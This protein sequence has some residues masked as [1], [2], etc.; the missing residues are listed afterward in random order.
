MEGHQQG[1]AAL[2]PPEAQQRVF[3]IDV[4]EPQQPHGRVAGSRGHEDGDDGPIAQV[5]QPVAG[6]AG[7][8]RLEVGER[9]ALGGGL[10]RGQQRVEGRPPAEPAE[11]VRHQIT[12]VEPP[13]DERTDGAD[14]GVDAIRGEHLRWSGGERASA[15]IGAA[16]PDAADLGPVAKVVDVGGQGRE[17]ERLGRGLDAHGLEPGEEAR[18]VVAVL[19]PS[20][21]A[22][23]D[24]EG[25]RELG[26]QRDERSFGRIL[27]PLA[28]CVSMTLY[29]VRRTLKAT[30]QGK[31][32]RAKMARSTAE[33]REAIRAILARTGLS[34]RA[35]S[36]G[37][38]RDPGYIAAYLD[39]TR[40]SRAR[41]TPADLVAASD[42]TGI[43]LVELLEAV[44]G[45][46][47]CRLADELGVVGGGSELGARYVT[48]SPVERAEVA[49]YIEFLASRHRRSGRAG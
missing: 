23:A 48:L 41:P 25:G 31:K 30:A 10:L 6:T 3:G 20:D 34:M 39:P 5:A 42:V 13:D 16:T 27:D 38:D 15:G 32:V 44:W 43:S 49:H 22:P 12:L 24:P 8:E 47:R 29:Y 1:L 17:A 7:L 40:P 35:L 36:A 4:I 18:E 28:R 45:I 11:W 21:G 33:A 9:S 14:I 37:M 26:N 46:D 19:L 2:A